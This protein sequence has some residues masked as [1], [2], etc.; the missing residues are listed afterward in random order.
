MKPK[1]KPE[2]AAELHRRF[3]VDGS[4]LLSIV[5]LWDH[6]REQQRAL[7]GNQFRRMCRTEF[8]NYL[9]VRE[10]M[11]LYSQLR[12]IAGQLGI[13]RDRQRGASHPDHVHQAVLAGLLSHIGMRDRERAVHR[14]PPVAIRHR[15]R[16]GAD[17]A[18]AGWV[19]AAELVETNQL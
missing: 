14:C 10:W 3:D 8:L 17:P 6:L 2:R 5:A 15:S 11:D 16:L 4:D 18:P 19:M 13:R 7:S 1:V 12:R 9:R